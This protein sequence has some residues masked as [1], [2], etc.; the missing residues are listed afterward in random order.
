MKLTI[1]NNEFKK[2][3][4]EA[5]DLAGKRKDLPIL[6]HALIDVNGGKLTLK[7]TDLECQI[8]SVVNDVNCHENRVF[9]LPSAKLKS[10]CA[11]LGDND[12]LKFTIGAE[13]VTLNVNRSKFKLVTLPTDGYPC[14][15]SKDAEHKIKIGSKVLQSLILKVLHTIPDRDVRY[16]LN[17]MFVK[18]VGDKLTVVGTDGH[19]LAVA[20]ADLS[21]SYADSRFILPYKA[22]LKLLKLLGSYDC[23]V[24]ISFNV[25]NASFDFGDFVLDTILI[26]GNYPDYERVLPKTNTKVLT[27][28]RMLLMSSIKRV[29]VLANTKHY[30]CTFDIKQ[31]QIDLYAGNAE[32]EN[33]TEVVDVE[34]C[35]DDLTFS[36]NLQYM[37][38]AL[39]TIAEDRVTLSF[40]NDT[41]PVL[42]SGLNETSSVCCIMPV[43]V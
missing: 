24:E 1:Q 25:N 27:V 9:T 5:S 12:V 13:A 7:A 19:R 4:T 17:G 37:L 38:S 33:A 22:V 21:S 6:D 42:V 20:S 29:A 30:S 2:L 32:L 41:T 40:T 23:D 18:V 31:N 11:A 26:D 10:I 16:F 34:Y 15:E 36:F 3:I 14:I 39:P 28:D 43:R 8:T 35:D